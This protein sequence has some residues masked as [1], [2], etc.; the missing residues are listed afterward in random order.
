M[1][2]TH[3]IALSEDLY[4]LLVRES[5]RRGVGPDAL[6]SEFVRQEL[7]A[8]AGGDLAVALRKLAELRERLPEIDGLA[9]ARAAR[10]ELERR[11]A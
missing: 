11:A 5:K 3:T 4:E 6:A 1:A 9:L 8:R 10:V 2:A 7:T